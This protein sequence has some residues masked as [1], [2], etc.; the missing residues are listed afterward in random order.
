MIGVDILK[1]IVA[2]WHESLKNPAEAQQQTLETLVEGYART[3]YGETCSANKV[4]DVAS[5][6]VNFPKIDY[7]G[8]RP[9]LEEVKAGN[10]SVI[11]PEPPVC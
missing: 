5:F 3:G 6:R 9:F 10:Y 2:P 1:H 4:S 11:L 7:V 8:L